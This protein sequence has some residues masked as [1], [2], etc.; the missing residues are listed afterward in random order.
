MLEKFVYINHIN[1]TVEFGDGGIFVNENNLRDYTWNATEKNNKISSFSKKVTTRTIPVVI[2]CN[3]EDEGMEIRNR[4]FEVIEK[5][6]LAMKHG[7]I[8]IGDYYLK[9]FVTAS[10]KKKYLST[11][12]SITISLT[13][14]TDYPYW[15]KETIETFG[16]GSGKPGKNLDYNTDHPYDYTSNMLGEQVA[17]TGIVPENF[18][19]RVYGACDNPQISIGGHLY[20][21]KVKIE[22]NEYLT[23]DSATKKIILK[24]T[25]GSETNCFNLRN[26]DSYIFEKIPTGINKVSANNDF[27]FDVTLYEERSEPKWT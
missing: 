17:N 1:E 4:L 2:L 25:N 11:K 24:H 8:V 7:R 6:V 23:I 12:T 15:I 16:Y 21:V 10:A 13:V 27:K 18:R 3:S 5:D 9:C 22:R 14:T 26:R 19:I 20:E